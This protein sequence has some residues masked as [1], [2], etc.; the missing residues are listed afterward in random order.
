MKDG[1]ERRSLFCQFI[2]DNSQLFATNDEKWIQ[3]FNKCIDFFQCENRRPS[4]N[5][6]NSNEKKTGIWLRDQLNRFKK[7]Q[8]NNHQMKLFTQFLNKY[9]DLFKSKEE[10]WFE[11]FASVNEFIKENK[12]KPLV[13]KINSNE[14]HL[15]MW[16]HHQLQNLKKNEESMKIGDKRRNVFLKFIEDNQQLFLNDD[17]KWDIMLEKCKLFIVSNNKRPSCTS[18]IEEER[19]LGI[20]I[21]TQIQNLKKNKNSTVI[22]NKKELF[23]NFMQ[24]N[25]DIFKTK[26]D[27]WFDS[28]KQ[29]QEW[30]QKTKKKLS[31]YSKNDEEKKLALWFRTNFD[32]L[33]SNSE[34]MKI[35]DKRRKVFQDFVENYPNIFCTLKEHWYI[36]FDKLKRKRKIKPIK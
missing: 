17:E 12:R 36:Y 27:I 33:K 28:F 23:L 11:K 34:A 32:N 5:S 25:E 7:S 10:T 3:N 21:V 6:T 19:S 4:T 24:E 20:W 15:S 14:T 9:K 31:H 2:N 16:L 35:G 13:N 1:D 8:L 22:E 29:Y 18:D 26:E 30:F